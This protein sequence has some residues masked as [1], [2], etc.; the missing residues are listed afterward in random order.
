MYSMRIVLLV[1]V[2]LSLN[3]IK[4]KKQNVLLI[5]VDD[6]RPLS[7]EYVRLPN[8]L[9]MAAK[10]VLFKNAFAQVS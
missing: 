8:I 6:L 3:E 1:F 5:Y 7:N 9:K 4:A 2:L 10:G